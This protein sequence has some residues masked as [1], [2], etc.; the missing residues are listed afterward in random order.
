MS[1]YVGHQHICVTFLFH[2]SFKAIFMYTIFIFKMLLFLVC[3]LSF[4]SDGV[5]HSKW[6]LHIQSFFEVP[7]KIT[8]HITL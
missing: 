8:C 5:F 2:Y 6:E 3:K 4:I 7:V 1:L